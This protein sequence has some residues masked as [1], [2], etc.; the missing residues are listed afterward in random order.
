MINLILTAEE[1]IFF[2]TTDCRVIKMILTMEEE[3]IPGFD[4][5]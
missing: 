5:R 4:L 2:L 1:E 3:E